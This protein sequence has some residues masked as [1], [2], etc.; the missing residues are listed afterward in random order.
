MHVAPA[1]A[2]RLC[3]VGK[4]AAEREAVIQMQEDSQFFCLAQCQKVIDVECVS[5]QM[6]LPGGCQ[7][8]WLQL[9]CLRG[10]LSLR[11]VKAEAASLLPMGG[12]GAGGTQFCWMGLGFQRLCFPWVEIFERKGAEHRIESSF[13]WSLPATLK[14]AVFALSKAVFYL[15][16]LCWCSICSV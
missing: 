1:R 14:F 5:S 12:L 11:G 15:V 6:V 3:L 4:R 13:P 8:P 9:L 10:F 7:H 2:D 16:I